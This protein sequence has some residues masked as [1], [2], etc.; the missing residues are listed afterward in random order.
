MNVIPLSAIQ[1]EKTYYQRNRYVILKRTKKYYES[2]K[3]RLWDNVIDKYWNL[4]EEEKNKKREYGRN[5][6]HIMSKEEKQKLREYQKNY[7]ESNKSKNT[8]FFI[9]LIMTLCFLVIDC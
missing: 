8:W 7:L 5:R 1:L 4:S 2:D 3:K 6:Y 9:D